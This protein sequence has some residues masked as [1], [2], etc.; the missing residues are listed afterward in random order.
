FLAFFHIMIRPCLS[1]MCSY[2]SRIRPARLSWKCGTSR[3]SWIIGPTL[4]A[5]WHGSPPPPL[6]GVFI[7]E[8]TMAE[9]GRMNVPTVI[10]LP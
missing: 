5:L 3:P 10:A 6:L 4:L 1:R 9:A 2:R 7:R 8:V